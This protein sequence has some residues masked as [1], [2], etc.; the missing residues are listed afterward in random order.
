MIVRRDVPVLELVPV[1]VIVWDPVIVT[2]VSD[3]LMNGNLAAFL[4]RELTSA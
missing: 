2:D 3:E 1:A 4:A